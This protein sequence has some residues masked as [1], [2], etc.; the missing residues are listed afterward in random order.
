MRDSE[1][2]LSICTPRDR[3]EGKAFLFSG[4]ARHIMYLGE[5][6]GQDAT[7]KYKNKGLDIA[8]YT[9]KGVIDWCSFSNPM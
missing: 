9:L 7:L 8:M 2:T 6:L 5:I 1:Q 3:E 4:I